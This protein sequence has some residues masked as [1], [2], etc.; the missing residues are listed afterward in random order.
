MSN[1]SSIHKQILFIV[2]HATEGESIVIRTIFSH[3]GKVIGMRQDTLS[4]EQEEVNAILAVI[5]KKH[6]SVGIYELDKLCSTP[7][8]LD[9]ER[10]NAT[11]RR[12][13]NNGARVVDI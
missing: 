5:D 6:L 8:T 3:V 10:M 1:W 12:M 7:I 4:D 9:A 2:E 13:M 11:A